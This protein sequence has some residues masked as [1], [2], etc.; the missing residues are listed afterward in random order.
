[1]AKVCTVVLLILGC[2]ASLRGVR[3]SSGFTH[4]YLLQ[5]Y[6]QTTDQFGRVRNG[7]QLEDVIVWGLLD[8]D[9]AV[10]RAITD[11]NLPC[12]QLMTNSLSTRDLRDSSR[13]QDSV[14][15]KVL[16]NVY[17]K[18]KS[19]HLEGFSLCGE[20]E[21]EVDFM[22]RGQ[23]QRYVEKLSEVGPIGQ[24]MQI[25]VR[26]SFFNSTSLLPDRL[27]VNTTLRC[28]RCSQGVSLPFE[29]VDLRTSSGGDY[30]KHHQPM[31]AFHFFNEELLPW[32]RPVRSPHRKKRALFSSLLK[33]IGSPC[34]RLRQKVRLE[35]VYEDRIILH[36][37]E[38]DMGICSGSCDL[39]LLLSRQ[40]STFATEHAIGKLKKGLKARCVPVS[41]YPLHIIEMDGHIQK[42]FVSRTLSVNQCGCR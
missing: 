22:L 33:H 23:R 20:S 18:R 30:A 3:A 10:D 38:I 21:V 27:V 40:H 26:T 17:I 34:K 24:W 8:D 7:V 39:R 13:E 31:L 9:T 28:R 25:K 14:V 2:S 29:L 16:W 19:Y 35:D 15:S 4:P 5:L 32:L 42:Q 6:N 36:P 37:R 41:Y 11:A 1:M 12:Q